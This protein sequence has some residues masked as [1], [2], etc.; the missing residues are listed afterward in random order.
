MK[1]HLIVVTL[2]LACLGLC[3][4]AEADDDDYATADE[5]GLMQGFPPSPEK[6][7]DR[8]NA[9]FGT[10]YN[11]W[12]YLHMRQLYPTA[13]IPNAPS[14]NHLPRSMDGGIERLMGAR[15]TVVRSTWK[16]GSRRPTPIR[17]W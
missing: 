17:W 5:L 3:P 2:A 16:P 14:P 8:S 12:S 9:L 13:G 6:R 7:V 10:P 15:T 4:L 11:R 1:S